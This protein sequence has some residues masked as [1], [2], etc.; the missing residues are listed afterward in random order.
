MRT[1]KEL[2]S[3]LRG[4]EKQED[5]PKELLKEYRKASFIEAQEEESNIYNRYELTMDITLDRLKKICLAEKD[6]RLLITP[7]N[8][9]DTVYV[10]G[11]WGNEP[12]I[13]KTVVKSMS[14]DGTLVCWEDI[15]VWFE[16]RFSDFGKTVF[17]E[18]EKEDAEQALKLKI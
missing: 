5:I 12:Y 3:E 18:S 6:G 4:Y 13:F 11:V 16:K 15:D 2:K 7:C 1:V 9:G 14:I 10:L 8:V 17:L